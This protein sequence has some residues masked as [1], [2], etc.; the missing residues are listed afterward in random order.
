MMI[1]SKLVLVTL[2]ALGMALPS[3]M[4]AQPP[5]VIDWRSIGRN[6]KIAARSEVDTMVDHPLSDYDFTGNQSWGITMRLDGPMW[7]H[8]SRWHTVKNAST[9]AENAERD[10]S[11]R[12]KAGMFKVGATVAGSV[13]WDQV[14]ARIQRWTNNDCLPGSSLMPEYSFYGHLETVFYMHFETENVMN[15]GNWVPK[16]NIYSDDNCGSYVTSLLGESA[17]AAW[18]LVHFSVLPFNQQL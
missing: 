4:P 15:L 7:L 9:P 2:A 1:A 10:H 6:N 5:N 3:E 11:P 12:S 8:E 18:N 14:C 13:A 17:C 16:M